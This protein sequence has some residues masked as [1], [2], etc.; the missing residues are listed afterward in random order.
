[1]YHPYGY[2]VASDFSDFLLSVFE[3]TSQSEDIY[4]DVN[5]RIITIFS[6]FL[7]SVAQGDR[8]SLRNGC[9]VL[10]NIFWLCGG[11]GVRS[12]RVD[13]KLI[14][15][16]ISTFL[17]SSSFVNKQE[18]SVANSSQLSNSCSSSERL[19]NNT[20]LQNMI[21]RCREFEGRVRAR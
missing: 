15:K 13:N 1:M 10:R 3:L 14:S 18:A 4:F 8:N 19:K 12:E 6:R 11:A 2:E 20:K 21:L 5:Q 16:L 9:E 17:P 7:E